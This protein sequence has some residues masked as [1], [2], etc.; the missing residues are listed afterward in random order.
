MSLQRSSDGLSGERPV[1]A[2]CL[3]RPLHSVLILAALVAGCAAPASQAPGAPPGA[4][5]TGP[6]AGAPAASAPAAASQ[7][8]ALPRVRAAYTAEAA[9]ELPLWVAN[10]AGLFKE[11]GLD[12]AV[13]RIAGGSSKAMQVMLAGELDVAQIGGTAVVDAQLAGADVVSIAT[14]VPVVGMSV[15]GVPG[16][17]RIED[18]RGK[19]LAMTRAGTITDFGA[20]LA[21]TRSGL[22]PETDV[23]LI[24]TGGVP[25]TLAAMQSGNV[26]GGIIITPFDV[27]AK[28]LGFHEVLDLPSLG[29]EFQHNGL[30]VRREYLQANEA[31][32]DRFL[33]AY[34][35]AVARA[36]QDKAYTKQVIGKYSSTED[37][38]A[39]E[40]GY[41][42]FGQ[43]Y[44]A[45]VP[46]PT[47]GQFQSIIDFTAERDPRARELRAENLIDDHF[48]RALEQEGFIDRLYR[49][50]S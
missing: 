30:T 5:A 12:V 2:R 24:Q 15:Y 14:V 27:P 22:R 16:I 17:A 31:V 28:K 6:G 25:E 45:R 34:V 4:P 44:L 33:R 35:A 21:L 40:S 11:Y 1:L 42:A 10:E 18:L 26:A 49:S 39:L 43:R 9:S 7:P 38:E 50:G 8:A 13:E 37:D 23:G 29:L 36:R 48:V 3:R 32:L 47:V 20:R 41:D 46:V 19:S